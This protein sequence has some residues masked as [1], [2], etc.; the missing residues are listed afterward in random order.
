MKTSQKVSFTI[1]VGSLKSSIYEAHCYARHFGSTDGTA[2]CPARP[3]AKQI[4]L[5]FAH[6]WLRDKLVPNRGKGVHQPD[7]PA[8]Q[9]NSMGNIRRHRKHVSRLEIF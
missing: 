4:G 5:F 2:N 7:M 1:Q 6:R 3:A 8:Q 9:L